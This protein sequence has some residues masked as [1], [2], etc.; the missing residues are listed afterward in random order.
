M[1]LTCSLELRTNSVWFCA[2]LISVSRYFSRKKGT[3][4]DSP[5]PLYELEPL[6]LFI[7]F[8]AGFIYKS[9]CITFSSLLLYNTNT[10]TGY[11]YSS[12]FLVFFLFQ[13]S[14][15]ISHK[16]LNKVL[17]CFLN[18]PQASLHVFN[19]C[20]HAFTGVCLRNLRV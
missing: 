10:S 9:C 5:W 6:I 8:T 16:C 14:L 12:L 13:I 1:A 15:Y 20:V 11:C 18:H 19:V 2:Y 7:I 4:W 3:S 17:L